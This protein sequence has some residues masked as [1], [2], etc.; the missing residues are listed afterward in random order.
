MKY[1]PHMRKKICL[2][3]KYQYTCLRRWTTG[4]EIHL[5]FHA[6]VGYLFHYATGETFPIWSH[7]C[8]CRWCYIYALK[9]NE[10]LPLDLTLIFYFSLHNYESKY[11]PVDDAH[12]ATPAEGTL[13][14]IYMDAQ[15]HIYVTIKINYRSIL[16]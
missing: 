1:K 7:S 15:Y 8:A 14:L 4:F 6:A 9:K 11:I 16:I 2:V 5:A 3:K 13:D 12:L 10:Y